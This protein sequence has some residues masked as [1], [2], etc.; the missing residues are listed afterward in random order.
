MSRP[1]KLIFLTILGPWLEVFNQLN[2]MI[3]GYTVYLQSMPINK[4]EVRNGN[5]LKFLLSSSRS[6]RV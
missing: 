6:G 5:G 1:I 2:M 4:N 3:S